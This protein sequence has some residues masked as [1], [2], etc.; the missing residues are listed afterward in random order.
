M[1]DRYQGRSQKQTDVGSDL[2]W[3]ICCQLHCKYLFIKRGFL[4]MSHLHIL[5]VT[6]KLMNGLRW[7]P[8]ILTDFMKTICRA[9]SRH[10]CSRTDMKDLSDGRTYFHSLMCEFFFYCKNDSLP[11]MGPRHIHV[12]VH[13]L[14][15][16]LSAT[17]RVQLSIEE[18]LR[19]YM[20][21]QSS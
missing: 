14:F 18:I 16:S 17:L 8:C 13:I 9:W 21:F 10:I 20:L 1:G 11:C 19:I 5:L 3:N 7:C 12:H 15:V 4:Q 2:W 6:L